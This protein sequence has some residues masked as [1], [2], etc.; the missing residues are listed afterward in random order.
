MTVL[1]Q[2]SSFSKKDKYMM[3]NNWKNEEKNPLVSLDYLQGM[4]L[5]KRRKKM[6]KKKK[7]FLFLSVSNRK[8]NFS[9]EGNRHSSLR[10][11]NF[12][13]NQTG[14]QILF[15]LYVLNYGRNF[16]SIGVRSFSYL[17]CTFCPMFTY[18]LL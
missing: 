12:S 8:L 10:R 7:S 9:D 1:L 14:E 5:F 2:G 18:F 4:M 3:A 16:P 11:W 6:K 17:P 15:F 13:R